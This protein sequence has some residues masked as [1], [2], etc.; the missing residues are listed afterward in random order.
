[1]GALLPMAYGPNDTT[2]VTATQQVAVQPKVIPYATRYW[3][4]DTR[5]T[6][7]ELG[8]TFRS[9][10]ETLGPTLEWLRDAGHIT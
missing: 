1:M 9:A 8:V 5:K 3:F 4:A 7:L 6:R 10:G 2:F